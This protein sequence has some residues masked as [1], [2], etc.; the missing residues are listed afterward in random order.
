MKRMIPAAF[1]ALAIVLFYW[2]PHQWL[3]YDEDAYFNMALA[4]SKGDLFLSTVDPIDGKLSSLLGIK[5]TLGNSCWLAIWIILL[6]KKYVYVSSVFVVLIGSWLVHKTVLKLGYHQAGFWWL[7][8]LLPIHFYSKTLMSDVPSFL[9]SSI[10][11][12][13]M[14]AMK[15]SR[16][17]WFV[18]CFI[19]VF[20]GW[21][22]EV[23]VALLGGICLTN[24]V[25]TRKYFFYYALG[26][27]LGVLPR[28]MSAWIVYDDPLIYI[29]AEPMKLENIISQAPLYLFLIFLLFPGL[30]VFLLS[31]RGTF[32]KE[33]IAGSILA[34]IAYWTYGY[35]ATEYSGFLRGSLVNSR[36]L[37]PLTPFVAI[38]VAW[39]F[40]NMSFPRWVVYGLAVGTIF[41]ITLAHYVVYEEHEKH[42]KVS[43]YIDQKYGD[44]LIYYDK[45]GL[46][47][48]PR[49]INPLAT[50]MSFTSNI[51]K[52][53]ND[54]YAAK[55]L[56]YKGEAYAIVSVNTANQIKSK[57]S[58]QMIGHIENHKIL[59]TTIY[60]EIDIEP[61]L[62]LR[63]YRLK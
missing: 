57:R 46:T 2:L 12:Y 10:F 22:R 3:M 11:L 6:S 48:I 51:V 41:V 33:I 18:L 50:D 38:C 40:R 21:F 53:D 43:Q 5:Y 31:Y 59:S 15:D 60:E 26:S 52:L 17:K 61:Q 4:L 14:I 39:F 19:A 16:M 35:D 24:F 42:R 47:N 32:Y 29:F 7:L 55:L 13:T 28:L 56:D 36:F 62:K 44:Y 27:I 63:V 23:N 58:N 54:E 34:L 30:I 9:I 8:L 49:Y 45:T 20:A 1:S 37:L 25:V